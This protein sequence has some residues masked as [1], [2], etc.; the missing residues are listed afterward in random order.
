MKIEDIRYIAK[1][2]LGRPDDEVE[3][4]LFSPCPEL[5]NRVPAIE[6]QY[7]EG[8]VAVLDLLGFETRGL[9]KDLYYEIG[10]L[11]AQ[12]QITLAAKNSL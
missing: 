10:M 5:G 8:E 1:S 2:I 9:A 3:R 11:L 12:N 7:L 6:C 4:W